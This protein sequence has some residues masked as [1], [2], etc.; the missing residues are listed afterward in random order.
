MA[1]LVIHGRDRTLYVRGAEAGAPLYTRQAERALRFDNADKARRW[2]GQQTL[3]PFG[4]LALLRA[5][6]ERAT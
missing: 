6:R 3:T 4:E 1:W 2:I 5:P